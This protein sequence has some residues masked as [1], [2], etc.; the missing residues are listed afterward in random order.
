MPSYANDFLYPNITKHTS[1]A[2]TVKGKIELGCGG[3]NGT[4]CYIVNSKEK[5]YM[6]DYGR[7][8]P[9]EKVDFLNTLEEY[10]SCV[11]VKGTL[12]PK[13]LG[14]FYQFDNRY[15]IEFNRC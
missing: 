9:Y 15:V 11:S 2:I 10:K 14:V 1:K 4:Y 12:S 8:L 7:D 3:S 13:K 5:Y 6:L